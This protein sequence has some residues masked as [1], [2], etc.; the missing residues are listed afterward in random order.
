MTVQQLVALR[1]QPRQVLPG[2]IPALGT[3]LPV[4]QVSPGALVAELARLAGVLEM[5]GAHQVSVAFPSGGFRVWWHGPLENFLG[6][7][8]SNGR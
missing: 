1:A 4:V 3:A 5:K 2:V 7:Q 8:G 6:F